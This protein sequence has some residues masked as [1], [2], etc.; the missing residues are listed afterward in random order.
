MWLQRG[1]KAG[2]EEEVEE[3]TRRE[4]G[5]GESYRA[6][7]SVPVVPFRKQVNLGLYKTEAIHPSV[8]QTPFSFLST[9][10]TLTVL[11]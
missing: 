11:L 9:S 3:G 4:E 6:S 8:S 7:L 5:K 1:S 10:L 2:R